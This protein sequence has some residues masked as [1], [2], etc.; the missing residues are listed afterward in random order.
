MSRGVIFL[1][2]FYIEQNKNVWNIKNFFRSTVKKENKIIINKNLAKLSIKKKSKIVKKIQAILASEKTKQIAIEKELKNDK[3]FVNLLYSYNLNICNKN[4]LFSR[5]LDKTIDSILKDKARAESEIWIC[6]ND[7][8]NNMEEELIK[9]A[10]EFKNINIVTKYIGKFKKIE[11]IIYLQYGILINI[12]NNKR[13]SLAKADLILNVD[14]PKEVINQFVIYDEAKIIDLYGDV[15]IKK[16]RFNGK[17]INDYN[18]EIDNN[19][20]ILK[21]VQRNQLENYD[22]RDIC[23]ALQ[24]VPEG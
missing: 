1:K 5:L 6:V 15:K 20:E 8:D 3:E 9:F 16:K 14:F 13:K 2:T 7:L 22:I 4:W 18:F 21:F 12:S 10:K 19:E 17:I 11:E 23:Q 24:I